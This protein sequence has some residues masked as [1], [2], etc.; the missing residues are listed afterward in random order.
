MSTTSILRT[1]NAL[2]SEVSGSTLAE[3][4]SALDKG[5]SWLKTYKQTDGS[6]YPSG[7]W[8]DP[9]VD[10]VEV[11]WLMDDLNIDLMMKNGAQVV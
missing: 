9:L 1:L 7:G 10:T 3:L 4:N 11:M 5:L 2:K 6:I 8:D